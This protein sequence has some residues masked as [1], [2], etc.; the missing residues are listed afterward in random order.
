MAR[1]ARRAER[2]RVLMEFEAK[3]PRRRRA[4]TRSD[5][6]QDARD[7]ATERETAAEKPRVRWKE[8]RAQLKKIGRRASAVKAS[9]DPDRP[10]NDASAREHWDFAL[11]KFRADEVTNPDAIKSPAKL[12]RSHRGSIYVGPYKE[13][14]ED[15]SPPARRRAG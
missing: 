10:G 3:A 9:N 5:V 6:L 15:G 14:D 1:R 7:A 2:K 13:E 12:G 8:V 11:G 4:A